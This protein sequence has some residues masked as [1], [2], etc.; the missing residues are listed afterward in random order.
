M[1]VETIDAMPGIQGTTSELHRQSIQVT[2]RGQRFASR[3]GRTAFS[4]HFCSRVSRFDP[5]VHSSNLRE[6]SL[7]SEREF[8]PRRWRSVS[9]NMIAAQVETLS[10]SAI[11]HIGRD[12]F[13][14]ADPIQ[15]SLSPNI[16]EPTAMATGPDNCVS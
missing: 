14:S 11:P 16:S 9:Y 2:R 10:E 5:F 6:S 1:G 13:R 15:G 12:T 4:H 8:Q 7:E 3:R